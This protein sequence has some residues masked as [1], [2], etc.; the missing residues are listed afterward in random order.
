MQVV[1]T[2]YDM[3]WRLTCAF[4]CGGGALGRKNKP[5]GEGP[6]ACAGPQVSLCSRVDKQ[7][8]LAHLQMAHL[9][10]T[11]PAQLLVGV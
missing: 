1:I 5:P 8:E 4:C 2:S 6:Q 11:C 7:E 9:R 10:A 3:M